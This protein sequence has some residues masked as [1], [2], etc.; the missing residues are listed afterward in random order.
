MDSS[1]FHLWRAC[2]LFCRID[3][4]VNAAEKKWMSEKIMTLPFT[5][6]Q[7]KIL[8]DDERSSPN[9][10]LLV[11]EITKPSDRAFLIDQMRVL[12]KIDG[13]VSEEEKAKIE[14]FR[15]KVLAK[16]DLNKLEKTIAE[17]EKASYH[18]DE[19]YKVDNESSW[20]ERLHR[21]VQKTA[22]PGDYKIPKKD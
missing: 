17:D 9:I 8:L 21:Y 18:E 16:V 5:P 19:V 22:N 4:V 1:K 7:K 12:A 14:S 15:Q 2:F 10:D 20:F 13:S 11:P 3:G 6:D